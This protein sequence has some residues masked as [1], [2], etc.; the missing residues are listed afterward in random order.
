MCEAAGYDV[1]IIETVGVGQSETAVAGMADMFVL[2]QLPNAGDDLQAIKKGVMELADLVV[3]NKADIDP[4]AATRAQ[5]QITSALRLFT[6]HGRDAGA[7][8]A[9]VL[10]LSALKAIGIDQPAIDA[11][12]MLEAAAGVSRL[13]IVTD[14][15]REITA[16]Q[17]LHV[18]TA[19]QG[20]SYV[21]HTTHNNREGDLC[22]RVAETVVGRDGVGEERLARPLDAAP[23]RHVPHELV[24]PPPRAHLEPAALHARERAPL[25]R[26]LLLHHRLRRHLRRR[27]R[28]H[29]H[30]HHHHRPKPPMAP[31]IE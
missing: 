11:R 18:T 4:D 7:W 13:E 17:A 3:I 15:Y 21:F 6:Q 30:H 10:Q 1:V 29:H 19:L 28:R 9:Q 24:H 16:E 26:R 23:R 12:L 20:R 5:A 31:D 8:R 22:F 2:L 14:P 27:R 25:S